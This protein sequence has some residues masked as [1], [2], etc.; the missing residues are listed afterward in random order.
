MSPRER[1]MVP[2]FEP[3]TYYDRPVLKEPTWKWEV[4]AYVFTGGLVAGSALLA[5]GAELVGERA[6]AGCAPSRRVRR[7]RA[8]RSSSPTSASPR[9]SATCCG[10]R[11]RARR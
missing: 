9:A 2:D 1:S 6:V 4:P 3:R 8:A 11:N 5:G 10:S 7:S